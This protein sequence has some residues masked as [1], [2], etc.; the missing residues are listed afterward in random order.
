[1]TVTEGRRTAQLQEAKPGRITSLDWVRGLFLCLSVGSAS[2][3]GPRPAALVHAEWIGVT[4]EDLVF[5]LFVILSGCGLAFAYRNA[6]GWGATV[7]RSVILLACGLVYNMIVAGSPDLSTLRWAGPLQVYAVLV[8]VIGL[9]HLVARRPSAWMGITLGLACAQAVFLYVWQ[10]SCPSDLLTPECNPSRVIDQAV[11]GTAHM[12]HGGTYGHDPEGLVSILGALVTACAGT[13]A[14]HLALRARGTWRAPVTLLGW[15]AAVGA[16]ALVAAVFLP[17]MKRLWTTPFALGV[18]ALGIVALAVGMAL[19]DM[20]TRRGWQ[21][22]RSRVSW[23]HVA[24]GRNSLLVY[25]G[26]HALMV[27]LKQASGHP[28]AARR[29]AHDVDFLGGHP[30]VSLVLVMV[31]FWAAL[32]AFLH[33]RRIYLR[34]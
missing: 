29:I 8:L 32:A 28:S 14:G 4:P 10:A 23:P 20:P 18:G 19:L 12:Y 27:V 13:T 1:M 26:S 17:A 5:P 16:A 7:K 2:L 9:L 3:L 6:V 31:V 33:W 15:A 21:A 22:L 24:M 30:R 11:L 25:F 34:P